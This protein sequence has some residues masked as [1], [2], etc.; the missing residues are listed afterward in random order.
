M[1]ATIE[2]P[3]KL[4]GKAIRRREDPKL[5]TGDGNFLD[6]IRLPGMAYAAILRSPVAHARIRGIDTSRA[7]TMPGVVAVFTGEDLADVNPLPC[8][9]QAAGVDN[10]VATPRLLALGEVRHVGDPLAVVVADSVYQANDALEAIEVD[11][12][13]LP[14]VV[15]AREA[16]KPG[17]PQLHENAPNN[18]VMH[19]TC[20]TDAETVDR[21]LA[22]AEV[23]V[24]QSLFN[25]RLIPTAIEPRGSIGVYDQ[26][27][28]EFTLWATS[29]APHVHRLVVA[30]FVLGIPEQKIR[31]IAPDVGGGFG[32]ENF[33][34]FDMP[35]VLLLLKDL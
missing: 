28:E 30:A 1:A 25:Q 32:S 18:I 9:W 29:Q 26:S 34:Y 6:D 19:W 11:F 5:M 22:E 21:A 2:A 33:V 16:V 4:V 27:T 15:D 7:R 3:E 12:E 17:A 23:R 13:E 8:A 31:V 14:V 24:S 35:V 20:G 10:N